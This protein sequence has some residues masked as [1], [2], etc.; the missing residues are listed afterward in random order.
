MNSD[1]HDVKAQYRR[2]ALNN[3]K[4]PG[5]VRPMEYRVDAVRSGTDVLAQEALSPRAVVADPT[6]MLSGGAYAGGATTAM[7]PFH[8]T[9]AAMTRLRFAAATHD[10]GI[11]EKAMDEASD[12]LVTH[13][14][15]DQIERVSAVGTRAEEFSAMDVVAAMPDWSTTGTWMGRAEDALVM[16]GVLAAVPHDHPARSAIEEY[17]RVLANPGVEAPL[18]QPYED[19]VHSALMNWAKVH[20]A[21]GWG[22]NS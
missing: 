19:K 7:D 14:P 15:P 2:K 10:E 9:T 16:C 12:A 18:L 22:I 8:P 4:T 21:N 11:M 1:M 5:A 20:E 6:L 17:T 13:G 3:L